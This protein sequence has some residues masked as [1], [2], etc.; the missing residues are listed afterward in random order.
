MFS[1]ALRRVV[2]QFIK[3]LVK[4]G[5]VWVRSPAKTMRSSCLSWPLEASSFLGLGVTESAENLNGCPTPHKHEN[6]SRPRL[7]DVLT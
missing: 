1:N 4:P 5:A 6:P 2:S 7:E 3:A